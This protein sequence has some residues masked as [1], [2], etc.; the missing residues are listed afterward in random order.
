MLF[1]TY[2]KLSVPVR[3]YSQFSTPNAQAGTQL[4]WTRGQDIWR[5]YTE[6]WVGVWGGGGCGGGLVYMCLNRCMYVLYMCFRR[7]GCVICVC[8]CVSV[9]SSRGTEVCV[10]G[11]CVCMGVWYDMLN[12]PSEEIYKFNSPMPDILIADYLNRRT[13]NNQRDI[14]M[15]TADQNIYKFYRII[16]CQ[17]I[18]L[19]CHT[20]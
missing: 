3:R 4:G 12:I 9:C 20:R 11:V 10:F 18:N 5:H 13:D 1:S 14:K 17:A 8:V 7:C 15:S 6:L 19:C 16:L 2:C